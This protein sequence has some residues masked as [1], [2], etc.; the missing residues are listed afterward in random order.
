[1]LVEAVEL[2]TVPL[3]LELR[4]LATLDGDGVTI[5]TK[6]RFHTKQADTAATG[7]ATR[8]S[9]VKRPKDAEHRLLGGA[10]VLFP[11]EAGPKLVA[12]FEEKYGESK[13]VGPSEAADFFST[14]WH[15]F[16]PRDLQAEDGFRELL[17]RRH[18]VW[19]LDEWR[20]KA[21]CEL[22]T[23]EQQ[24]LQDAWNDTA[25]GRAGGRL[26]SPPAWPGRV[27]LA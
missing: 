11:G 16:Q 13:D 26:P 20:R 14:F 7:G 8:G 22:I 2:L 19:L 21:L 15:E 23:R 12:Q 3:L 9:A 25:A 18:A 1:M 5:R 27:E 17:Q 6:A 10:A 24:T 4:C